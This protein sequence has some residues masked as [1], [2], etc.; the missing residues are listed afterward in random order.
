MS[1]PGI[2]SPF[3]VPFAINEFETTLAATCG[4]NVNDVC[5]LTS[6]TNLADSP[7]T[8]PTSG[9][10]YIDQGQTT[11][12]RVRYTTL[13]VGALTVVLAG[14]GLSGSTAQAHAGGVTFSI[15]VFSNYVDDIVIQLQDTTNG[16]D[17]D[18]TNSK[19]VILV[20][21]NPIGSTTPNTGAFTTLTATT[22]TAATSIV[23]T[24][25]ISAT[26]TLT[27]NATSHFIGQ[28][29]FE[30]GTVFNSSISVAPSSTQYAISMGGTFTTGGDQSGLLYSNTTISTGVTHAGSFFDQTMV[31]DM[32]SYSSYRSRVSVPVGKTLS[33]RY[34]LKLDDNQ[35]AGTVT[36]SSVLYFGTEFSSATVGAGGAAA[37]LPATPQG[38]FFVHAPT[39]LMKVP[40]YLP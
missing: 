39:G 26:G 25:T 3:P 35:G 23:S 5:T 24:G 4:A 30:Y 21:P 14:R 11:E 22:I 34:G 38:Y 17:H 10:A 7:V 13:N 31:L 8:I 18:G 32:T 1:A 6:V 15:N 12:E 33:A 36:E 37:A 27:A 16:H 28:A 29:T 40:Y 19:K 2:T 20:S 9:Y